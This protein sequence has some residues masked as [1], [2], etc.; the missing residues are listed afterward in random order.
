MPTTTVP[1]SKSPLSSTTV[2]LQGTGA[3]AFTYMLLGA[4]VKKLFHVELPF[5]PEEA[6]A[7]V[8]AVIGAVTTVGALL[9][10]FKKPVQAPITGTKA[11]KR[12]NGE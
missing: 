9:K 4:V 6:S 12:L 5:S 3:L 10:R 7:A 11:S 2:L 1:E 8:V